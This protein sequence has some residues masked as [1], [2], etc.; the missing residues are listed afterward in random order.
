MDEQ[1]ERIELFSAL[2]G[3]QDLIGWFGRVPSF[4]DA[5]VVAIHLRRTGPSELK[6]HT[7]QMTD[8]TDDKGFF[9]LDKHVVVTFGLEGISASK[10]VGF[11]GG[12]ILDYIDLWRHRVGK[13]IK[14]ESWLHQGP[15]RDGH[16]ALMLDGSNGCQGF[17]YAGS[18]SIAFAPGKPAD[19]RH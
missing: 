7:W 1:S 8:Q 10:L 11:D 12:G 6:L 18:I 15:P 16:Y 2:P 13:E 3:A 14:D 19:A 17:I 4:H 9:L 5:E